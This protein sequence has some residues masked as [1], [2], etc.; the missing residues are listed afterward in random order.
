MN[1]FEVHRK[2]AAIFANI[3]VVWGLSRNGRCPPLI[4][5]LRPINSRIARARRENVTF[6]P[7]KRYI[8]TFANF[9]CSI[10]IAI[11]K[12]IGNFQVYIRRYNNNVTF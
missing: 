7:Y 2:D 8:I 10:N 4:L 9:A 1:A 11:Y 5:I 3:L 12:F 6:Q